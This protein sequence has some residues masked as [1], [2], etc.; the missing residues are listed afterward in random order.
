MKP[1]KRML[2]LAMV[3]VFVVAF[4]PALWADDLQKVNINKAGVEELMRLKNVGKA[5]A[6]RIVQYREENGPF[7]APE[8]ITKV[9]GIGMRT[10][11]VNKEII[12]VE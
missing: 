11:E 10:Y 12:V 4:A 1:Q 2:L 6:E 8:D 3:A 5:Y 9:K 7:K